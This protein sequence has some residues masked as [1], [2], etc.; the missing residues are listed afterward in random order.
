MKQYL[1]HI[2]Q[3]FP[4]ELLF[5][6]TALIVIWYLEPA[7]AAHFSLCPLD[8]LGA[9]WCPG[10]GLGRAMNLLMHGDWLAS[11]SMHPLAGFA[12]V[13]ILLR[14]VKLIKNFKNYHY[15]G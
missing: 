2:V 1:Q 12:F 10:C 14:I 13:V 11:F 9:S 8:Q 15:Y 6:I 5:W 4:L 3:K 7:G